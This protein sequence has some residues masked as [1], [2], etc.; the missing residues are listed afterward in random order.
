MAVAV[1][2]SPRRAR[3]RFS[4][5]RARPEGLLS[6]QRSY[7]H[8]TNLP[9]MMPDHELSAFLMTVTQAVDLA[10]DGAPAAGYEVLLAGLQRAEGLHAEGLS[11]AEELVGR[12]LDARKRFAVRWGVGRG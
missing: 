4:T 7:R 8:P 9:P 12:Y 2:A 6:C 5:H 1:G 11:W 10:R 3:S